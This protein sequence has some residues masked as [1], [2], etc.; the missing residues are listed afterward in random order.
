MMPVT[1]AWNSARHFLIIPCN[2]ISHATHTKSMMHF[3]LPCRGETLVVLRKKTG[4][5]LLF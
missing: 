4:G 2:Y 3:Y 5:K 1:V